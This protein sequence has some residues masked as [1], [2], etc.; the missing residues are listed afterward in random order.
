VASRVRTLSE[1]INHH[2]TIV[3]AAF[4]VTLI[5]VLA[6]TAALSSAGATVPASLLALKAFLTGPAALLTILPFSIASTSMVNFQQFYE[7]PRQ[8]KYQRAVM[9][10]Y[11]RMD[12]DVPQLVSE[13]A[14]GKLLKNNR[15][16]QKL[17]MI[18][19]TFDLWDVG[20][21]FRHR[22]WEA[23]WKA[24]KDLRASVRAAHARLANPP[25]TETV[26]RAR[27][28]LGNLRKLPQPR[29]RRR[30][31]SAASAGIDGFLAPRP[32]ELAC[33]QA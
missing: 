18:F 32:D 23:L 9:D 17:Q 19:T 1:R 28:G 20:T 5:S 26:R 25:S 27:R 13:P 24:G 2:A 12:P 22:S 30:A 15:R 33:R 10:S 8:L 21:V 4:M 16:D 11:L 6:T 7:I 3:L 31:P 14:Y 29:V